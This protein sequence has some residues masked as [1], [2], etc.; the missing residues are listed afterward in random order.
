MFTSSNWV[1]QAK[2][3]VV[4]FT[5]MCRPLEERHHI[6]ARALGSVPLSR[7]LVLIH[8]LVCA[9]PL[10]VLLWGDWHF[11]IRLT[12]LMWK[13][14]LRINIDY[15]TWNCIHDMQRIYY[16]AFLCVL[17]VQLC[18]YCWYT[19]QFIICVDKNTVYSNVFINIITNKSH[20]QKTY[21]SSRAG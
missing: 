20:L 8:G 13:C 9:T 1:L 21:L 16:S 19:V 15:Q 18:H 6:I 10:F 4:D 17:L 7:Y 12:I 3:T 5:R 11:S 14:S 2:K